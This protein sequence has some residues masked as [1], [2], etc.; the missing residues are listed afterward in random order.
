MPKI[1]ETLESNSEIFENLRP[2][3]QPVVVVQ[4]EGGLQKRKGGG[5]IKIQDGQT[6][7][8]FGGKVAHLFYYLLKAMDQVW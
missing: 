7:R 6:D 5:G 3:F 1:C 4:S 2:T 8:S